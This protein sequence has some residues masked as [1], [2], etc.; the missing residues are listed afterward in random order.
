MDTDFS[1]AERGVRSSESWPQK[2]AEGGYRGFLTTDEHGWTGINAG[3]EQEET[4]GTEIED[5]RWKIAV[6][7]FAYLD[8]FSSHRAVSKVSVAFVTSCEFVFTGRAF[9]W[10]ASVS[11]RG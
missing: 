10:C 2:N 4:E 8:G 11:I 3:G 6:G 7:R 5:G 1:N 9:Y